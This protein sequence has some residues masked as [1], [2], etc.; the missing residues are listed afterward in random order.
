MPYEFEGQDATMKV[1]A[2]NSSSDAAILQEIQ[3]HAGAI[4]EGVGALLTARSIGTSAHV[5]SITDTHVVIGGYGVVFGG[6]DL[7]GDTF[8]PTTDF[9]LEREAKGMPVFYD[10]ELHPTLRGQI[11]FVKAITPDET[12]LFFELELDRSKAYVDEVLKL[13]EAGKVGL[14][15]GA[16]SHLVQ[17]DTKS[18]TRW[19]VGEVSL[20][21][22]PAEPRTIGL[23]RTVK[24][25]KEK[26]MPEETQAVTTETAENTV[27]ST[28]KAILDPQFANI[29]DAQAEQSRRIK[30]IWDAINNAPATSAG[31]AVKTMTDAEQSEAHI[32]AW[33][34]YIRTGDR[35]ALKE[36]KASLIEG[37]D[38]RGGYLVPTVYSNEL[39]RALKDMSILRMAGARVLE[40]QG[41][42]SFRV[43][44]MTQT[45][46]AVKTD[47]NGAF[48]ET[49]P[50]FG[51]ITFSPTKYT[52][53]V[54]VSDELLEDS[55][56]DITSRVLM[57]DYM[58]AFAAAENEDF[59]TGDG[60]DDPQGVTV[61]ASD[62]GVDTAT[63]T[64]ISADNI[65]D[66]YHALGYLYRQNAVWLM[67]DTTI[68]EIRKLKETSTGQYLWQPGLQAGQP[69]RILGRPVYTLN[70]MPELGTEGNKV[71]I[72][73]DMQFFWIVDFGMARAQMRRLDELYA[74]TGQVGFRAY[75]RVDSRVMLSEAIKYVAAGA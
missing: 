73:G 8:L 2:R 41:T 61:G 72:F 43:P 40:I 54:K 22:T 51:E 16:L 6:E 21:V 26:T 38:E 24:K 32:K 60:T 44:T 65:V 33:K 31:S 12:G 14:S 58:Q 9:G 19:V 3:G 23:Q 57:P 10:H 39:I 64:T 59:A 67:H 28:V 11:G 42:D 47:E 62:S 37:T 29:R 56:I 18:I 35:G 36:I 48:D 27:E 63:A 7:V 5:K 30:E 25:E 45:T 20:T 68:K 69:D 46:R 15:T 50:T 13:V 70:T 53:L 1:G 4:I 71:I 34:D 55:R 75:K 66:A 17:T 52:R 74:G 49:E